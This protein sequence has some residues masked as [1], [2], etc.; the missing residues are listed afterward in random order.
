MAR[1]IPITPPG[2]RRQFL[3]HIFTLAGKEKKIQPWG[4]AG[5][6]PKVSAVGV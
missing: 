2:K 1:K 3:N 6:A 4:I 5:P